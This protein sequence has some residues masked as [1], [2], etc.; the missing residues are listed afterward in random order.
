MDEWLLVDLGAFAAVATDA[1]NL[2]DMSPDL[3]SILGFNSVFQFFYKALVEMHRVFAGV[4]DQMMMVFSRFDHLVTTL[5][6]TEI[7]RLH[8]AH[9]DQRFQRAIDRGQARRF[10]LARAHFAVDILGAR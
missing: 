7:D 3:E 5:T 4:A 9:V 6:V 2:E 1:E 10:V 8:Q